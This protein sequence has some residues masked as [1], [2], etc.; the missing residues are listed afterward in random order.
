[1]LKIY[2]QLWETSLSPNRY[3]TFLHASFAA[4]VYFISTDSDLSK[5]SF[6]TSADRATG[7]N[8][9]SEADK[10][11]QTHTHIY[12][13]H[14]IA[15]YSC[16]DSVQQLPTRVW[17]NPFIK[18]G[19]KLLSFGKCGKLSTCAWL[20]F[21]TFNGPE[22]GK[23]KDVSDPSCVTIRVCSFFRQWRDLGTFISNW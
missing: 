5:E 15:H 20:W 17:H 16:W 13:M 7:I 21:S 3:N 19:N 10:H 12:C 18:T 22:K 6:A 1:M 11:M 8:I 23:Y 9:T 14:T 2:T 4:G